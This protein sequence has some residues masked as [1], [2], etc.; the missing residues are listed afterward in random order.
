MRLRVRLRSRLHSS[1][2]EFEAECVLFLGA[3]QGR[4]SFGHSALE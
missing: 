1:V 3:L 4:V 2:R